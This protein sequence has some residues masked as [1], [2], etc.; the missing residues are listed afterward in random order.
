MYK[1]VNIDSK[2]KMMLHS[3]RNLV[4]LFQMLDD[5]V[6]KY[7]RLAI[8]DDQGDI[9]AGKAATLE[10]MQRQQAYNINQF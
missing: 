7:T 10:A 5:N 6:Y 8:I 2:N 4:T 3:S 9:V 1:L